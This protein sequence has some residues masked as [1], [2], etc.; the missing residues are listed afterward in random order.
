MKRKGAS[1]MCRD[2]SSVLAMITPGIIRLLMENRRLGVG[3]ASDILY[4]SQL[5]KSLEDEGTKMWRLGYPLLYDLLE[6]ELAT[7]KITFPEEQS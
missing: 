7:G 1:E 2:I 4:N 5:Y 3:E 6:E